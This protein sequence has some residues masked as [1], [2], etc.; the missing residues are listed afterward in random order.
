MEQAIRDYI[1]GWY[2]KD[3][4]RI[5]QAV[6]PLLA[7]QGIM[8]DGEGGVRSID[9]AGF[10]DVTPVYGGDPSGK[11]TIEMKIL[12]TD[13]DIASAMII[14]NDYVDYLHLVRIDGRWQI[15]NV[16]WEIRSPDTGAHLSQGVQELEKPLRDY[17]E[18]WYDKDAAR[19]GESL[20]PNLAKRSLNPESPG[21][22]DQYTRSSLLDVV[23]QYGGP[24]GTGRIFEMTVL[25]VKNQIA[26]VRL[27]SNSF[28]DHVHLVRQDSQ[29]KILNVLWKWK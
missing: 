11:R 4:A 8:P 26:S 28:V 18:G 9:L 14:S 17:A 21:G 3:T 19:V 12:G 27:V 10:L 7:K 23:E 15:L 24:G 22:I 25:D 6:H 13:G 1:E 20:H 5:R 29:W 2:D 16:L